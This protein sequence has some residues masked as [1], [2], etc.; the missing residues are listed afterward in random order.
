M[1]EIISIKISKF[2]TND[3]VT[4]I[5]Q[6]QWGSQNP[7]WI[8]RSRQYVFDELINNNDCFGV[9]A[10]NSNEEIIGRMHCVKN[11]SDPKLWYYGDLF[12]EKEYRRNGIASRMIKTA[13]DHLSEIGASELICYV[14]PQNTASRNLQL[15]IGFTERT[16]MNFNNFICDGEI[17]YSL[18]IPTCYSVIPAII[19]EAY[20]V[21]VLFVLNRDAL[22]T[23]DISYSEWKTLLSANDNDEKHFLVCKGAVPVAYMKINGLASKNNAWLS[24]LFVAPQFQHQGVGKFAIDY[25]EK[26]VIQNGFGRLSIQ[27]T[28]ENTPAQN[29]YKK[30]GFAEVNRNEKILFVKQLNTNY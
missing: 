24:M 12:V 14:E 17:M 1:K 9:V 29:L 28:S 11:E 27:T 26:F 8:N 3:Y 18:N 10:V 22:E 2:L 16:F 7:E 23:D 30:C 4:Q 15:S 25:A 5:A 19:N 6:K 20:F 21:R 13:V